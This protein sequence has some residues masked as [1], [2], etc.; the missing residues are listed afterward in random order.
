MATRTAE[1]LV[2]LKPGQAVILGGMITERTVEEEDGI[3]IL[4]DIPVVGFLFKSRLEAT[5]LATLLFF[6]RPRVLEGTDLMQDF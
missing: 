4:M 1:T 6:I 2:Y 5:E 3:P